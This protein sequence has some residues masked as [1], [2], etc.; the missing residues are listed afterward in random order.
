M[1]A[2]TFIVLSFA[3]YR[4]VRLWQL[5]TITEKLRR[6]VNR[7]LVGDGSAYIEANNPPTWDR[8][9]LW[10]LDLINC[11]WCLGL[12]VAFGMTAVTW[13]FTDWTPNAWEY[14][15]WSLAIAAVQSWMH[16]LEDKLF[17]DDD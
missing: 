7:W 3:V 14:I 1:T 6:K 5:D 15:V 8:F 4:V 12:W 9:K 13:A 11:L 17:D 16:G 2:L 10:L